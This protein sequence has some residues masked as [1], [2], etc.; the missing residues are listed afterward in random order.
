MLLFLG[1][2]VRQIPDYLNVSFWLIYHFISH[3]EGGYLYQNHYTQYNI[4][5][6][7][8]NAEFLIFVQLVNLPWI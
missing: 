7:G 6:L 3:A 5:Y 2:L 1:L 8:C 4:S